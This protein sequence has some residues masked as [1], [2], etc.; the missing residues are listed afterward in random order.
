MPFLDRL[1]QKLDKWNAKLEQVNAQLEQQRQQQLQQQQQQPQ[2]STS[3]QASPAYP[4]PPPPLP[5]RPTSSQIPNGPI[6][7][8]S[9][10]K[11]E[12]TNAWQTPPPTPPAPNSNWQS[13][14]T[15][16]W[17]P[18]QA[19]PATSTFQT[20]PPP[21]PSAPYLT[22]PPTQLAAP[23]SPSTL[24]PASANL[25][26]TIT[27]DSSSELEPHPILQQTVD[28]YKA[29]EAAVPPTATP[30]YQSRLKSLLDAISKTQEETAAKAEAA[31][32]AQYT[33]EVFSG[34]TDAW[35][36]L[37][38]NPCAEAMRAG[39]ADMEGNYWEIVR[40]KTDGM[41]EEDIHEWAR[42]MEM[43]FRGCERL[44]MDWG[45]LEREKREQE[46]TGKSTWLYNNRRDD[47]VYEAVREVERAKDYQDKVAQAE[48]SSA[49][50]ARTN[51]YANEIVGPFLQA[52]ISAC[53]TRR[54]EIGN[55]ISALCPL[56]PTPPDPKDVDN[57]PPLTPRATE[58]LVRQLR[59]TAHAYDTLTFRIQSIYERLDS[60][61]RMLQ[62]SS[63][64]AELD[65]LLL[66]Q[67]NP[68]DT[69]GNQSAWDTRNARQNAQSNES[70]AL[71]NS[72]VAARDAR[73]DETQAVVRPCWD[74]VVKWERDRRNELM[75][76]AAAGPGGAAFLSNMMTMQHASAMGVISNIGS[77]NTR[78]EL[79][80]TDQYGNVRY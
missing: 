51:Q 56:L 68:N 74:R 30:E 3:S 31:R 32:F 38:Y 67:Y 18:Q 40:S 69:W 4:G 64:Q 13:P 14:P 11:V 55:V 75:A 16:A 28:A 62:E 21:P 7:S 33:Q 34:G 29:A 65:A 48:S 37:C 25:S 70:I 47:G 78:W 15:I 8:I 54:K 23:T 73:R 19:H 80:Y 71:I 39:L 42:A 20:P 22:A 9:A 12:A 6:A 63:H 41:G 10:A 45:N 57:V 59:D 5:P 36:R 66:K 61:D 58:A 76:K 35:F 1:N 72:Q 53:V 60:L 52:F 49:T 27:A 50:H 26:V 24:I 46:S 43:G 79:Q 2:W 17:Q 77:S 44:R